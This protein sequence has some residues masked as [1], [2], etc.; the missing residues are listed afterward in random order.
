MAENKTKQANESVEAFLNKVDN[1]QKRADCI[2][3]AKLMEE[4]TG[5]KAKMWGPSIVG[6]GSYH[7][8]YESGREGDSCV[9]GFSP[10]KQNITLYLMGAVAN[11]PDLVAKLG[12]CKTGGG[13]LYINKLAEVDTKVLKQLIKKSVAW[14]KKTY[15]Q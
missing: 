6:F 4:V 1:E 9:V 7:Y 10:R 14:V 5:E 13:C 8:K 3:V 15:P 11:E 12:K 2:A